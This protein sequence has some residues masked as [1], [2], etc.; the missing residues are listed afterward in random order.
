MIDLTELI[1]K[2]LQ[3]ADECEMLGGLAATHNERVRY[4]ERADK[5]RC[6]ALEARRA[7][8]ILDR[9]AQRLEWL[10]LAPKRGGQP[11]E[12]YAKTNES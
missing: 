9:C 2:Y 7:R 10:N 6:L 1:D 5:L 12:A 11:A 4:R 8:V 3:E